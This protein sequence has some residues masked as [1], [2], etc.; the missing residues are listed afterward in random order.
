M[1][2]T[3]SED[4]HEETGG[5]IEPRLR[6]MAPLV[7]IGGPQGQANRLPGHAPQRA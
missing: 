5:Q 4:L 6:R 2:R 3:T 7:D 1:E